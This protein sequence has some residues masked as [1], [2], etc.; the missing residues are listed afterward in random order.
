MRGVARIHHPAGHESDVTPA[1]RTGSERLRAKLLHEHRHAGRLALLD[2]AAR[3]REIERP[4]AGAALAAGNY[5][6]Q[7]W[8]RA[9]FEIARSLTS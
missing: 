8:P 4:R 2:D 3:P 7:R 1:L 5:P 9:T 6:V